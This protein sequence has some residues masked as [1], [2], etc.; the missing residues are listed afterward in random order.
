MSRE[1]D[2]YAAGIMDGEGSISIHKKIDS[3]VLVVQVGVTDY[4][5][6]DWLQFFYGGHINSYQPKGD[7][8]EVHIW[9]LHGEKAQEFI[10]SILPHLKLKKYKA[11]LALEYK[12]GGG[13]EDHKAIYE[14]YCEMRSTKA[15]HLRGLRKGD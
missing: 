5:L 8:K 4:E 6:V 15:N 7:R 12:V 11:L 1:N 3:F 9:K 13:Y 2:A 14:R 10:R